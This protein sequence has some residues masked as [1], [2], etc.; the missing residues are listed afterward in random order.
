MRK[1]TIGTI[2]AA[3]LLALAGSANAAG[4]K[5]ATFTVNAAVAS[6]CTI[7][8]ANLAF[9]SYDG[10]AQVDSSSDVTVKCSKN[11]PY[12]LSL[13]TGAGTYVTRLMSNGAETLQYNLYTDAG[14][15][16]VWG[17]GPGAT[18]T[19]TGTG[20]NNSLTHTVYGSVFNNAANQAAGVGNY[21]DSIQVTVSY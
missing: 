10:T 21:S 17:S 3:V 18:V 7:T 6:N 16:T 19:G 5:N 8:A 12:T 9:G 4:S 11:A 14:R 15:S 20:L 1:Q 13:S 2:S